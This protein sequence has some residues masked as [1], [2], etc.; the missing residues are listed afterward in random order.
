MS[1]DENI[2][3]PNSASLWLNHSPVGADVPLVRDCARDVCRLCFVLSAWE[4]GTD[5][6]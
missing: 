1:N 4:E 6:R 2:V 5:Q 3:R